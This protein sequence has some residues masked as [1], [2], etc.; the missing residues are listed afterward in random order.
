MGGCLYLF[1]DRCGRASSPARARR[2]GRGQRVRTRRARACTRRRARG[3][4]AGAGAAR[5]GG[6]RLA[7]PRSASCARGE[8][9]V[10]A[11]WVPL[12][13][14]PAVSLLE[15]LG[16]S[17]CRL[18]LCRC[19]AARCGLLPS[20]VASSRLAR[21]RRQ[22]GTAGKAARGPRRARLLPVS[23]T[24]ALQPRAPVGLASMSSMSGAP[25]RQRRSA[26]CSARSSCPQSPDPRSRFRGLAPRAVG[27]LCSPSCDRLHAYLSSRRQDHR[28]T[29]QSAA[30]ASML[31]ASGEAERRVRQRGSMRVCGA[32]EP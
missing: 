14:A 3:P 8:P 25:R 6:H 18:L 1:R 4:V 7:D 22:R 15:G 17:L 12:S 23:D 31:L 9:D 24:L 16:C 5:G 2:P 21:S 13:Q 28:L 20:A 29:P 32:A 30:H 27:P 26:L 10:G 11:A 19:P